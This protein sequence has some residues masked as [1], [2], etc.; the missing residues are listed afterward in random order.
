[1]S[2]WWLAALVAWSVAVHGATD[3]TALRVSIGGR[4]TTLALEDYVAR[5]IAGEG[6]PRAAPGAQEAL[7]ITAR[8]YALANRNR[9]RREG[10]DLCDTTHC[11]VVRPATALTRRAAQATAG[12]V[13]MHQGQPASV[14]YSA[15]CGGHS[16]LASHVWPGADDASSHLQSDEA[17]RAEPGWSLELRA[18]DIERALRS[19]GHTG[20]LRDVRVVQRNESGRVARV[21]VDGMTPNELSGHDFR[22]AMTRQM[23]V[24]SVKSTAF[25]IHRRGSQFRFSGTGFGHGVGLCVIGAG[26][27]A[28]QGG[29]ADAILRFYFPRLSVERYGGVVARAPGAA[30]PRP[31]PAPPRVTEPPAAKL[32]TGILVTVANAA[33]PDRAEI[34]RHVRAARDRIAAAT[35]LPPR[36]EIR[37]VVHPTID[38]FV[39]ATG[40]PWW[41]SG[42][43]DG[44]QID[45]VPMVLLRQRAQVERTILREVARLLVDSALED[46]PMWVREGAVA[47]FAEPSSKDVSVRGRCPADDELMRPVS[48]GAHR[49]ALARAEA[50]FRREIARGKTWR[51]IR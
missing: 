49:N 39:R 45:L 17:C 41:V 23:G 29:S 6:Q 2:R 3:E 21:R 32:E 5:V 20:R 12:R 34:T 46:K 26:R 11:Q 13:L 48:A 38:A 40:Q 35:G 31:T 8:T 16:E 4:V 36:G 47:Y 18:R 30:K 33:S 15:L 50:C 27:R 14:F 22:M 19:A 1:M 37:V 10:F 7:A 25:D 28:A 51:Q 42:M 43:S 9:H 24:S 44:A